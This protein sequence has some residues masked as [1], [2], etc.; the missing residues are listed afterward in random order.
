MEEVGAGTGA[1]ANGR[2]GFYLITTDIMGPYGVAFSMGTLGW[3]PGEL[4]SDCNRR[5]WTNKHRNRALY[6]L[7]FHGWV[8]WVSNLEG[9]S[10]HR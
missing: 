10:W 2:A 9:I 6:C 1:G 3:G 8:L 7:R 4:N 5:R